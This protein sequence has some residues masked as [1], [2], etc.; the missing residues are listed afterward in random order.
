[1]HIEG[2]GCSIDIGMQLTVHTITLSDNTLQLIL[3][4]R[5]STKWRSKERGGKA[6]LL[7]LIESIRQIA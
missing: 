7:K 3:H 2:T 6:P 4:K 5:M 1:M